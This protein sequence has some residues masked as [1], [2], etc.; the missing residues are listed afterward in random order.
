MRSGCFSYPIIFF[1]QGKREVKLTFFPEIG[2]QLDFAALGAY[3]CFQG[4]G[5]RNL[6]RNAEKTALSSGGYNDISTR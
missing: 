2:I 5:I 4:I 6:V 1:V 3:P